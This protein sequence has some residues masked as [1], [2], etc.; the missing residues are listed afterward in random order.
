[1]KAGYGVWITGLRRHPGTCDDPGWC[2]RLPT[3][4][5]RFLKRRSPMRNSDGN[6]SRT[7]TLHHGLC[8]QGRS[9]RLRTRTEHWWSRLCRTFHA[10][11][12][13]EVS[14]CL[15][16]AAR[17]RSVGGLMN[18]RRLRG[19]AGSVGGPPPPPPILV[20]H[21]KGGGPIRG[22]SVVDHSQT[23]RDQEGKPS[24]DETCPGIG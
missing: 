10:T 12:L 8:P 16:F 11:G 6:N 15:K 22:V 4:P 18:G 24:L 14:T 23:A 7:C 9:P 5:L 2:V 13:T 21:R 17:L 1:M 20:T 3:V 19:R